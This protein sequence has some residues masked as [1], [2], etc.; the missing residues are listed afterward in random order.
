MI[1]KD[2]ESEHQNISVLHLKKHIRV[3][4]VKIRYFNCKLVGCRKKIISDKFKA[5][6][7]ISTRSEKRLNVFVKII[8][9]LLRNQTMAIL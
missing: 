3:F 7:L 1:L 5:K 8:I 2:S 4:P 6:N 9:F